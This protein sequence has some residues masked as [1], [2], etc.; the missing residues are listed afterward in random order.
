MQRLLQGRPVKLLAKGNSA[1]YHSPVCLQTVVR[2]VIDVADAK[3]VHIGPEKFPGK[4][5][6]W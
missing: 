4:V 6:F 5:N 3:F 1:G 2:L